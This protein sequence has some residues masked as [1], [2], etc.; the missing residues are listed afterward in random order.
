MPSGVPWSFVLDFAGV[1][2][3]LDLIWDWSEV[4]DL[5]AHMQL[6]Q[7]CDASCHRLVCAGT[8]S[9]FEIMPLREHPC[10]RAGFQLTARK[11]CPRLTRSLL[12]LTRKLSL[13]LTAMSG[14]K[15]VFPFLVPLGREAAWWVHYEGKCFAMVHIEDYM[16]VCWHGLGAPPVV[17][18]KERKRRFERCSG[19]APLHVEE[20]DEESL[21][22]IDLGNLY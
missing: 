18:K 21:F 19:L 1:I 8:M 12:F 5:D 6:V 13:D 17:G 4:E 7:R 15:I 10:A 20:S 22:D 2:F 16:D 9:S 14:Q 3:E 11:W